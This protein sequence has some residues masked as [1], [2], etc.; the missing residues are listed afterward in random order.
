MMGVALQE[1]SVV[2]SVV[3]DENKQAGF[4]RDLTRRE[5]FQTMSEGNLPAKREH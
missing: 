4:K 2:R 5:G 1:G 3:G